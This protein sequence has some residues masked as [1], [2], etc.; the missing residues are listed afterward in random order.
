MT[1]SIGA[2]FQ[3]DMILAYPMQH[4]ILII[5]SLKYCSKN[6]QESIIT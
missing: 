3:F 2:E 1:G 5:F 4:A 6:E